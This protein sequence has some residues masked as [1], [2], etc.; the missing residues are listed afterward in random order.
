MAT[1]AAAAASTVC[2]EQTGGNGH[3]VQK[4]DEADTEFN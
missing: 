3:Y 2:K 4:H 1:L